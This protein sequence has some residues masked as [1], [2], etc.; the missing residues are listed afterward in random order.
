NG[1]AYGKGISSLFNFDSF[2]I[3]LLHFSVHLK[4]KR[5]KCFLHNVPLPVFMLM[6]T[7]D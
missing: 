4:R 5:F 2:F 3:D 1:G 7:M 6:A